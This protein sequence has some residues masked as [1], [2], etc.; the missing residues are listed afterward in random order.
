MDNT[1]S[2]LL[3]VLLPF[4]MTQNGSHLST[5]LDAWV[6][7]CQLQKQ[8]K[9]FYWYNIEKQ[10]YSTKII[11]INKIFIIFVLMVASDDHL[12]CFFMIM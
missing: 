12:T 11:L 4:V 8:T 10:K 9:V 1:K 6:K 5:A 7:S 3:E 2:Q